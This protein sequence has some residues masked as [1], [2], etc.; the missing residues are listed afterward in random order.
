MAI[1]IPGSNKNC[2]KKPKFGS[3]SNK[4]VN[5]KTWKQSTGTGIFRYLDTFSILD[6]WSISRLFFVFRCFGNPESTQDEDVAQ[7]ARGFHVI[8]RIKNTGKQ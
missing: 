3:V 7:T 6:G 4:D 8:R 2:C 5:L 1:W